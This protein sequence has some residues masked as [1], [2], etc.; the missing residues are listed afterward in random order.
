M[1]PGKCSCFQISLFSSIDKNW[2]VQ[3]WEL[4]ISS[5]FSLCNT[6]TNKFSLKGF[7]LLFFSIIIDLGCCLVTQSCLTIYDPVDCSMPGLSILHHI[8]ELVQT[9]VHWVS[10]SSHHLVLCHPILLLLSIFPKSR[11]FLMSWFFASCGQSIGAS[12]NISPSNEYSGL[13]S[14]RIDWFDL[15]AVPGRYISYPDFRYKARET[16]NVYY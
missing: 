6:L 5:L 4:F 7:N 12:V 10:Y 1:E 15:F 16:W 11:S 8:L 13:I 14:F 2:V 9:H 3:K